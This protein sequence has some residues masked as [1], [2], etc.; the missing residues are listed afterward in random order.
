VDISAPELPIHF[1]S[2]TVLHKGEQ[3]AQQFAAEIGITVQH[4][5]QTAKKCPLPCAGRK[6]PISGICAGKFF[7]VEIILGMCYVTQ[8]L[9]KEVDENRVSVPIL[10]LTPPISGDPVGVS[11]IQRRRYSKDVCNLPPFWLQANRG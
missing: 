9:F 5:L 7:P 2:R 8:Q 3:K 1:A 11:A 4:T 6:I 10:E